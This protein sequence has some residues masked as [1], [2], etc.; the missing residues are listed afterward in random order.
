MTAAGLEL[1]GYVPSF[2]AP[3]GKGLRT[4][5]V[6]LEVDGSPDMDGASIVAFTSGSGCVEGFHKINFATSST[7]PWFALSC[8]EA[9][10]NS[11]PMILGDATTAESFFVNGGA[12][13]RTGGA[14]ALVTI[15]GGVVVQTDA[16]ATYRFG[17]TEP[18]L[19]QLHL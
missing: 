9:F 15:P 10:T 3:G 14:H 5:S 6:P 13:E 18:T 12:G 4:L 1:Y 2:L 7:N 17:T 8:N 11:R 16:P 19:T